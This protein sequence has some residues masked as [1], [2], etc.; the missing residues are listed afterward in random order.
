[1]KLFFLFTFALIINL[2]Y[3][4]KKQCSC[5][6]DSLIDQNTTDCKTT[7]L[8]NKA[9]LY[10]QFNC[11]SI[12]LTLQNKEGR[13]IILDKVPIEYYSYTFRLG[14][15]LVKE[16]KNSL[17]FRS[18]CPA[19]GPCNFVLINKNTGKLI[20]EFGEL[21]YDHE[22]RKFYDFIL[23][24]SSP[25]KLALHYIDSDKKYT[26][27]VDS[28]HFKAV[29]PEYLFEKIEL[30]KTKLILVYD[31]GQLNKNGTIVIDLNKY[32]SK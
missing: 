4:Q 26:I 14:Y 15:R 11:D 8:Q 24:F 18:G 27:G 31:V 29:I 20:H 32:P 22:I 1:M 19:N 17:L 2:T 10:W 13:R 3:G 21:I 7:V 28:T 6:A 5:T 9:L 12:W 25:G 30:E 23:Y 16:Y